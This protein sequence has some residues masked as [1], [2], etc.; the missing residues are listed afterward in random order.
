[1]KNR[2]FTKKVEEITVE[3]SQKTAESVKISGDLQKDRAYLKQSLGDSFDIKYRSLSVSGRE[4]LFVMLDGMCDNLLI[5][6]QIM[7]PVSKGDFSSFDGDGALSHAADRVS[8]SIDKSVTRDME[9]AIAEM[10]SGNLLMLAEGGGFAVL[11]GVQYFA[12]RTPD[13]PNTESQERGSREGFVESFKDNVAMVRRRVRSPVLKIKTLEVGATSKTRVCVMYMSDR[14]DMKMVDEAVNSIKNA[15][16][17]VVLGSGYLQ[18]FLNR[19]KYSIF[20]C[21]A[22]TERPDVFCAKLGE[23]KIGII[24]DGTPDAIVV[25]HLFIESFHSLDDYLKRAYYA[26]FARVLK[27]MSFVLSVFLPGFYVA[28]CT[29]HQEMIP[30]AMVFSI[31]SQESKTPLP[32]VAE[33]LLIHFI[34]EIVREAGLRIPKSVGNA[35]SIVGALVIGEAAVM[36]GIVA[37]P[38]LIV[39]GLTAVSSFVVASLYEPVAILRF[40]FIIVGGIAGLYG[41]VFGFAAVLVNLA[42]LSSMGV[43]YTSPLSPTKPGAWRDMIGRESW[44]QM[45]RRRM[46]IDKLKK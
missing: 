31:T 11:F 21:N 24:V 2:W 44:R 40:V 18:P 8:G 23:G 12:K 15:Q 22:T 39:V 9:T 29:F 4:F 37:A 14:A 45:G 41:I 13:E 30:E 1:M 7:L 19:N 3:D 10:L 36:A 26:A 16:L 20:S 32:I 46:Q 17:D 25:P 34:Y 28:V 27:I 5:T 33:A 42:S 43:P 35:I 38:M 6:E